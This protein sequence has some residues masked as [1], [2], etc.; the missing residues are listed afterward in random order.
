MNT[1]GMADSAGFGPGTTVHR[2]TFGMADRT[3]AVVVA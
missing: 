3:A 1:F 2:N